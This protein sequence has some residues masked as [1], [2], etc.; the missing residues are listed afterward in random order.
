[1]KFMDGF[2][3]I[4]DTKSGITA[5]SKETTAKSDALQKYISS[6]KKLKLKG[7]IVEKS[8]AGW[9]VLTDGKWGSLKDFN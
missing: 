9:Q 7:G 4:Y 2:V 8:P 5:E 1:M 3:G 6:N